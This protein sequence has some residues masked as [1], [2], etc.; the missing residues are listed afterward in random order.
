MSE[1]VLGLQ[2]FRDVDPYSAVHQPAS[3]ELTVPHPLK[4]FVS[5]ITK[6]SYVS[7]SGFDVRG[8]RT[9]IVQVPQLPTTLGRAASNAMEWVATRYI[10]LRT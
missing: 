10:G 6:L 4:G 9:S 7:V 8:S 1:R 2:V 5:D 3:L